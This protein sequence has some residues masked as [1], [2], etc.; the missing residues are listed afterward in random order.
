MSLGITID[1][2][3]TIAGIPRESFKSREFTV[4]GTDSYGEIGNY[5]FTLTIFDDF[6]STW[7][8]TYL[9]A[10]SSNS[11]EIQLPLVFE[12]SYNFVVDWWD[13]SKS[14]IKTWDSLDKKHTYASEGTYTILISGEFTGFAFYDAGDKLKL[15]NI[16]KF[17][18]FKF[19][20]TGSYFQ[21]AANFEPTAVDTPDMI[22]TTN[23]DWAFAGAT[24]FN[25]E[26]IDNLDTSSV[27]SMDGSF[28]NT[29]SFNQ[30]INNWDTLN[31]T[32]MNSMFQGASAFNQP[33]NNWDT[34]N[35]TSM[36]Y[37]FMDAINFDG[38]LNNWNISNVTN[39]IAT[40]YNSESF[41]QDLSLWKPNSATS[42]E[43][44]FYY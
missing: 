34:S 7:D 10:G 41:N 5:S 8:T 38:Y 40:F 2:S 27:T 14:T 44:M 39:F 31:V 17:G 42:M 20:N 43:S 30:P 16:S 36:S 9:S 28:N 21:G 22:G 13:G 15:L 3:C 18:S 19:G 25:L 6:V 37:M 24:L 11:N 23:L 29:T 4:T 12:G 1:D 35:V 33:I 32:S 26:S